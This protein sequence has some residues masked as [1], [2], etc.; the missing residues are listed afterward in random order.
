VSLGD[1]EHEAASLWRTLP[2][3]AV[4]WLTGELGSGKTAFAQA[5]G[6]AAGAPPVHS[7]TFALVHEYPSQAGVLIHVDCYRL[8]TPDEAFDLDF[9]DL[10]RRA[11]MLLIEWPEHAGAHAPAPD[12]HLAFSHV[13]DPALRLLAR[14]R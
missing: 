13:D 7:P 4:V 1:L 3:G 8:R 5:I 11:R 14:L 9:P 6:R 2:V 12:A 10:Q